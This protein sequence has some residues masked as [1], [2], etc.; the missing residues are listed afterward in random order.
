MN[1]QIVRKIA[2]SLG[3]EICR[4]NPSSSH[5]A[6]LLAALK[7]V[8]SNVVLD[9]GAN[10]GQFAKE[11]RA[12]GFDGEII[13]F[14][15]LSSAH[16]RL[17]LSASHDKTWRV[18]SRVALGDKKGMATI[19]IAAN[20]VSSS[21]LPM[22]D[23]HLMA[24][25]ESVYSSSESTDVVTLDSVA[26]FYLKED[27]RPFI[28]IDTQGFEWQVLDG[29]PETLKKARGVLLEL[30]LIPLYDGQRMWLELI[31]RMAADGFTV[32]ALQEG[33]T[34][35]KNGRTLQID[36]VFLRSQKN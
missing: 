8:D 33:F 28:K 17:K 21:I 4:Y 2:R 29:A 31:D 26:P 19:N 36:A 1:M 14:E 20:S 25:K 27:S 6:Q 24:A 5:S 35:L 32:W 11:L 9:I 15:P 18:H 22:L 13:S 30:S 12:S 16:E 10:I 34:D 23:S 7:F 3:L